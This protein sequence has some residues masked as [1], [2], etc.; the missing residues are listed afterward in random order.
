MRSC[1]YT[2]VQR[3]MRAIGNG[4][5]A[6]LRRDDSLLPHLCADP[7]FQL[8]GTELLFYST[9]EM[10]RVELRFCLAPVHI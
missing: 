6:K 4:L 3:V 10:L 8:A 1:D 7:Q 5:H 9:P 2:C